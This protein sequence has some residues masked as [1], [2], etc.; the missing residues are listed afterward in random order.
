MT[1][2]LKY[3]TVF[4]SQ[5]TASREALSQRERESASATRHAMKHQ[6]AYVITA[7][8]RMEMCA[9]IPVKWCLNGFNCSWCVKAARSRYA[10]V[11]AGTAECANLSSDAKSYRVSERVILTHTH[12]HTHTPME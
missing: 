6:H 8:S 4:L 11:G 1:Q 3:F 2:G 9:A 10:K 7:A 5:S 12:T